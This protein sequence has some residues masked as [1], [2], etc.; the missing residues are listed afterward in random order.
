LHLELN[1]PDKANYIMVSVACQRA[2]AGTG[3][4]AGCKLAE[5]KELLSAA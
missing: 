3:D 5:K 4:M 1:V 2:N